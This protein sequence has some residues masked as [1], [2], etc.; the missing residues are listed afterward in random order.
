MKVTARDVA[1][2]AGASPSAVSRAFQPGAP[3]APE[4]RAR[5]LKV[6]KELGYVT[7]SGRS[8]N[9]LAT[10]SVSMI[11]ED[12][13]N[14]F[15]PV[16]IE[17][18]AQALHAR[19]KRLILHTVPP[20]GSVDP[21]LQSVLDYKSDAAIVAS[22]QMS[23]K[24]AEAFRRRNM[25]LILLNR[26]QPDPE[27]T[28]VTC[29]NYGGGRMIAERLLRAGARRIGHITGAA[30]TSTHVERARGFLEVLTAAGVR[31]FATEGGAFSYEGGRAAALALFSRGEPPDALFCENDVMALAAID[32]ARE[33]GLH[34]LRDLRVI[35]FDDIPMASWAS[36][37]LTTVRQPI[38]QMVAE[39]LDLIDALSS[40]R[41]FAGAIRVLP[42]RMIER[43]SG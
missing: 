9:Q 4:L 34:A 26:V 15:Y 25:P 36:Y 31:P 11:A 40:G 32:A 41:A 21:V 43:E 24:V 35:G 39:T 37:R 7:P 27:M 16:A 30:N 22:A 2:R 38:R 42:V 5:I 10:G 3:I 6:A 29:D 13:S 12:L 17:Y 18:L 8:L 33:R 20:G 23:S 28:A 1:L 19:G 14:P